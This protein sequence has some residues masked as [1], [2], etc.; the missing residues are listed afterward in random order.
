MKRTNLGIVAGTVMMALLGSTVARAGD[1]EIVNPNQPAPPAPQTQVTVPAA[2][3]PVQPVAVEPVAPPVRKEVHEDVQ[4]PHNIMGTIAVS[5][6]MGGVVG[7]LVGG[8]IYFLG[9]HQDHAARIGYWAA[10]GVLLGTGV[11]IVQVV[12]DE[13][14]ADQAVSSAWSPN[15]AHTYRVALFTKHF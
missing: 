8:A 9:D 14:R 2:P 11:G 1:V 15:P 13:S 12:A 3:P 4:A 7:A 6:L 10:G 5:A